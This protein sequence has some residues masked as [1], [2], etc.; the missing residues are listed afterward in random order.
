MQISI[1]MSM[2]FIFG[3]DRNEALCSS[4]IFVYLY[5]RINLQPQTYFGSSLTS[6]LTSIQKQI[7]EYD[8]KSKYPEE[9][10]TA[11][12]VGSEK[13]FASKFCFV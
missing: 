7:V 5:T 10:S 12:K 13:P 11:N 8:I 3:D 9:Y 6:I 4:R 1:V 2:L